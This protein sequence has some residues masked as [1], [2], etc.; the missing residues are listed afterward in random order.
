MK[1]KLFS[2]LVLNVLI[3]SFFSADQARASRNTTGSSS[4]MVQRGGA[5]IKFTQR[6]ISEVNKKLRHTIKARYPQA[7]GANRDARLAKLNQALRSLASTE[8][9]GFKRDFTPPEEPMGEMQSYYESEYAISLVT[10][11]VVSI[12]FGVSTYGEGA[13]HPNHHTL[14]FNYDLRTGQTLSLADL[15][16]PNS[17]YLKIIS[18]YA[19]KELK[20][21]LSPEPDED[22]IERGAGAS[23]ENYKAWNI[24]R[25]GLV[26]TFDPYQVAS[27]AE[28]EHVVVVPYSVLKDLIVPSGALA[29][30]T[31]NKR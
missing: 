18:G 19:I 14:V 11:E 4:L 9:A 20:K 3:L 2:T 10:D 6:Q 7:V 15:F 12:A 17:N 27:Y 31:A 30:V 21:K 5:I 25:D 24:A 23:E 8:V 29:R 13:A 28:G 16:K 26:V 22:W 1:I